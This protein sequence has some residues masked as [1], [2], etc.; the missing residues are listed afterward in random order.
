VAKS[1]GKDLEP[2]GEVMLV[3][4]CPNLESALAVVEYLGTPTKDGDPPIPLLRDE[5]KVLLPTFED[6]CIY[7]T[8]QLLARILPRE[9]FG[10]W[11]VGYRHDECQ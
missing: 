4:Y 9:K 11:D 5:R 6:T 2:L 10:Y 3:I 8:F 1:P 7:E